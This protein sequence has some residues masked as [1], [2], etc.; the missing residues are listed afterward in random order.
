MT[1]LHDPLNQKFLGNTKPEKNG[2]EII[3]HLIQV[4]FLCHLRILR[5]CIK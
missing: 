4:L 3:L 2:M 5:Q 1:K